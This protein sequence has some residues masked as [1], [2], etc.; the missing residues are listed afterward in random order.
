MPPISD[1]LCVERGAAGV[2]L[3]SM[4]SDELSA[5]FEMMSASN[6]RHFPFAIA[7]RAATEFGILPETT[8]AIFFGEFMFIRSN[9]I[10]VWHKSTLNPHRAWNFS[11]KLFV[12]VNLGA[13]RASGDVDSALNP[14]TILV[15]SFRTG[16]CGAWDASCVSC[17]E[18][19]VD[20]PAPSMA[21]SS[22][23]G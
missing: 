3:I 13:E 22:V 15:S 8:C 21:D 16:R 12:Q 2:V 18:F 7:L 1:G 20:G 11:L 23:Q 17:F 6:A 9:E 5:G 4:Q 10:S 19:N 14:Q